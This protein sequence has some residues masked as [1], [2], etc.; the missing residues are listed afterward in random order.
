MIEKYVF[1][2]ET[3]LPTTYIKTKKHKNM[4]QKATKQ[5]CWIGNEQHCMLCTVF[6]MLWF[7]VAM[8]LPHPRP[9][10]VSSKTPPVTHY[11]CATFVSQFPPWCIPFPA[12]LTLYIS[13]CTQLTDAHQNISIATR[14]VE[15][16]KH[17]RTYENNSLDS[18]F[19]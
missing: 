13:L 19:F 7:A 10:W 9:Y 6:S 18:V 4:K 8:D 11:A 2:V 1:A 17:T 3:K 14:D 15:I 16:N 5:G 12:S